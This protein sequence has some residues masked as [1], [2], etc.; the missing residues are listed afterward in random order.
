LQCHI[1]QAF[2]AFSMEKIKIIFVIFAL[3]TSLCAN[4]VAH[5]EYYSAEIKGSE[6]AV[7]NKKNLDIAKRYLLKNGQTCT[8]SNMYNNN[9]CFATQHYYFYLNPD[10]GGP[11]HHSQWNI[12]CDPKLGD[13]NTLVIR[14]NDQQKEI[15]KD[16][17][18]FIDRLD[19]SLD[20]IDKQKVEIWFYGPKTEIP[21]T[22]TIESSAIAL[23]ELLRAIKARK[24]SKPIPG[25]RSKQASQKDRQDFAKAFKKI[26]KNKTIELK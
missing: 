19:V 15:V 5:A 1:L 16:G 17:K 12:N 22:A 10:P 20:F 11:H 24:K 7:L 6:D 9:P 8:W 26:N 2:S 25:I 23:K 4:T 3:I 21:A 13:F 18:V 14:S